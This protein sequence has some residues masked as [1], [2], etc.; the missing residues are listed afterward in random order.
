MV[1]AINARVLSERRGGP[2]RYTANLLRELAAID[3]SNTYILLLKESV[4]FGFELPPNFKVK[5]IKS[6]NRVFFDYIYLPFFSWRTKI[7]YFI[8]PKNTFSPLIRGK[9]LPVY[10][11]IIYYENVGYREFSFWDHLHHRVM[12]RINSRTSDMDITVSDFTASRMKALLGINDSKIIVAKEGVESNFVTV[13][14]KNDLLPVKRKYNITKPFL[15]YTGSLSPRKNMINLLKAF[16]MVKDKI[17]HNLYFTGGDS[18]RDNDVF[19]FIKD[20][21]LENRVVKLGFVD[22]AE[23]V[24]LYNLADCYM[25]PSRYEGFGLPIL[26]AQACGCPVITSTVSS[27][28]EIAGDSALLVDPEKPEEIAD[29]IFRIVTD[30]ALRKSLIEKGYANCKRFSWRTMAE[31]IHSAIEEHYKRTHP[32]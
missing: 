20:N 2:A 18:W 24:S 17:E 31:R 23:L 6:N 14:N 4:S 1:I 25:Y 15:F 11:D 26:E 12:I 8:F 9:K 10:H 27:C 13:A 7:D 16:V 5:I 29:A 30:P 28:P 22:D 21:H 19:R 3:R 32:K